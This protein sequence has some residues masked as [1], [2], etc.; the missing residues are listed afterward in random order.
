MSQW[1]SDRKFQQQIRQ[2]VGCR[3]GRMMG[4]RYLPIAPARGLPGHLGML[5]EAGALKPPDNEYGWHKSSIGQM[6]SC[7]P[8]AAESR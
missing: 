4:G 2:S 8:A 5:V 6:W 1:R 7:G 3:D